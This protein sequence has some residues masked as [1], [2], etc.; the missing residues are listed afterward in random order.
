MAYRSYRGRRTSRL[1]QGLFAASVLILLAAIAFAVIHNLT[2]KSPGVQAGDVPGSASG[3]PASDSPAPGSPSP[4]QPAPP[5]ES[6]SPEP[7]PSP[8]EP[9]ELPWY[10]TLVNPSHSL[11]EDFAAELTTIGNTGM[12]F[13]SRA[14]EALRNMISGCRDAGLQPYICSAYRTQETQEALFQRQLDLYLAAGLSYDDAYAATATAIAIPG[15]S[16]HQLGLAADI[17]D[18]NNQ[19]LDE[20]QE[21]TPVQ[22]WLMAHCWEYGFILRYPNDKSEITQIIYEPWHYRYVGEEYAQKITDS[23]LCLEE[24]L[25]QEFGVE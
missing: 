12:S 5:S 9:P 3:S 17:V 15:T 18:I 13:D 11:P 16:E 24:Y 6:V 25:L 20:S 21:S 14:Y 23:G 10:L 7:S 8:S 22:Q 4:E 19:Y 2:N 1:A